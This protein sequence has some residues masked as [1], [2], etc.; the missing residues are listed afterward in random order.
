MSVGGAPPRT[1]DTMDTEMPSLSSPYLYAT[2][3]FGTRVPGVKGRWTVQIAV[4]GELLGEKA[5]IVE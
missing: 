5:F 1:T 4:D 3:A 2:I